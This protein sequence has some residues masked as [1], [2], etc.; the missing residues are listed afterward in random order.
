METEAGRERSTGGWGA[1]PILALGLL[2]SCG[3][4][5]AGVVASSGSSG[6][7]TTP[8]LT[9]FAVP[10]PKVSPAPIT[11]EA[12]TSLQV[13]MQFSVGSGPDLPMSLMPGPGISGNRVQLASGANG[14]DWDFAADLGGAH[15]TRDVTLHAKRGGAPVQGGELALFGMGNDAPI[16]LAVEPLPSDPSDPEESTGIVELRITLRDSSS[17][18][19]DL[20]VEWRRASGPADAWN[21][22]SFAG[23]P[24]GGVET[25]ETGR[26]FSFFWNTN[27]DLDGQE[28]AVFFRVTPDDRTEVG[29]HFLTERTQPAF[30]VDN[31][32]EPIVQLQNDLVVTNPDERRGIPVPFRVIDE[33]GDLVEVIFQWRRE[34][35]EFPELPEAEL[36]AILAD[37]I[38]R[39][40]KHICTEYPHFASGRV[41]PI[42]ATHVRLPELALGSQSWILASGL[43]GKT[44][45]L[46]RP[47]SIP[48]P[49]TP[50]WSSNPLVSPVAALPLGDGLTALVLDG[51][52]PGRL[53]EIELAT[54]MIVRET[55]TL[56][57]GIPR[58]M[59]FEANS[60]PPGAV[61]VT[62]DDAGVWRIERV[63]LASGTTTELVVSDGTEPASV[64]GIASLGSNAAVFTAGSSLF[65][66]DYSDPLA[67]QV[68]ALLSNLAAP[69][70]V[71][72]DSLATNQVYVA[73]R[74]AVTPNGTGRILAVE[75]DSHGSLPV[76][77]K[78]ADMIPAGL[79]RPT[80]LALEQGGSRML[81]V[82]SAPG[83]ASQLVSLDLGAEGGNVAFP[84]GGPAASEI[85]FIAAGAEGLRMVPLPDSSELLVGGGLE[86]RRMIVTF[87]ESEQSVTVD[88]AFGP[89]AWPGTSW[90]TPAGRV[91][92]ASAAGLEASFTWS[93]AADIPDGGGASLQALARDNEL[94]AP[95][96]GATPKNLRAALDVAP[97]ALGG[98]PTTDGPAS[99]AL[100]DLDAD[101]DT[102]L[103]S[104]NGNSDN[105]TVFFQEAPRSFSSAAFALGDSSTTNSPQY[106]ALCDLGG[107]GDV[108]VVSANRDG[109]D[110]TVFPQQ[111]PGSF[112][113]PFT[114]RDFPTT[115]GPACV[116]LGDLDGDGDEDLVS[117]N[118]LSSNLT[119]FF[120]EFGNFPSSPLEL[121]SLSITSVPLSVALGDL[122]GDGDL[123]LVSANNGGFVPN[124]TVFFQQAPGSF[125]SPPRVLSPPSRNAPASAAIGDLDGDGDLDVV[126]ANVG[127]G[128]FGEGSNLTVF[129]QSTP[130][131]FSSPALVLGGSSSMR[132]PVSVAL[133][134]LD[135]DGDTDLVAA[136]AVGD[137][138]AVFFQGPPGSFGSSLLALG[139]FPI[140][141]GVRGVALGDLDGDS[142]V[143]VVAANG[144]GDNL[145]VFFQSLPSLDSTP[146]VLGDFST[147]RFPVAVAL[148]DLDGNGTTDLVSANQGFPGTT[149]DN[150][151][152]FFQR[153]HGSFASTSREL[154]GSSNS[155]SVA[156]GDLD[157]DGDM[158]VA[159]I[160]DG[161]G[162][163]PIFFQGAPGSFGSPPLALGGPSMTI[164][165]SSV[166][167]GDLDGDGALD[168]L[169]ANAGGDDLTVFFQVAP[170][171]FEST[172]ALGG[173]PITDAPVSVALGDLDQDGDLEVVSANEVG[174]DLA[175]F[176]QVGPG[177][178]ASSPALG[179]SSTTTGP[180]SVALGDLDGDGTPDLASA[181]AGGNSLTVFF[182]ESPGSFTS[183]PLLLGGSSTTDGPCSVALAD[184]D[185]DGDLDL[186]SAN[187][188]GHDL[189]VFFQKTLG[190]FESVPL[191]LGG[192]TTL[193][194]R[195]VAL[196]DLDGDGDQDLVS[197]NTVGNNLAVFWGG[198]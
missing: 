50:S 99:V 171:S 135:G 148:G 26:E 119:V 163:L 175:V 33:E 86:Q 4:G 100:G 155:V 146:L 111:S 124:L 160:D 141:D 126:S 97:L 95:S 138:L 64:R 19:V 56:G 180:R 149:S 16:V 191:S 106:V 168:L 6:G 72:V 45:E 81:I 29:E 74:D 25:N 123:D 24:P 7:G 60:L 98:F 113:S 145:T 165:S 1:S 151:S 198:R 127:R 114:L 76:V 150:L 67:P 43:E 27:L 102:D 15:L 190:G 112:A 142:G 47:S 32:A 196:G 178:F 87:E 65:F 78:T 57:P 37:P 52:G 21:P 147:T 39:R 153:S 143:D 70:G 5:V 20:T 129:F 137:D 58:A 3:A 128:A 54:G 144:V 41:I 192:A 173:F 154:G 179:G 109:N 182:Q 195:S 53:R 71:I 51:T 120:Q 77:V 96:R 167:L 101:G 44:L 133:D 189:T 10:N 193:G 36:D 156:V 187:R 197:A 79:E 186:A 2:S 140:T 94:G 183:L 107:D 11:L 63:E 59:A 13:E 194:P 130:G 108:D 92:R 104:A 84:I 75:L 89:E 49:I 28:A 115:R 91:L 162:F 184:L 117:A 131:G 35:E 161:T 121:G 88:A 134:D 40:E 157:G 73:E 22:A 80:A 132:R 83:G 17:D 158:D 23:A 42:D 93:S 174:N 118:T 14:F 82:T 170:R 38:R 164:N 177:S 103:I 116:A 48:Q 68:S 30:R 69:W 61:L 12:S 139:G 136:D 159:S 169:S 66:L 105:L 122:D 181:N 172:L 55:T 188:I 152:A 62:L 31:N 166:V 176:F 34:N 185:G 90:R 125:T 9:A 8:A 46:L 85:T 18:L 110:V